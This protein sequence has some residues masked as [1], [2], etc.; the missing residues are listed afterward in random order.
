[1]I[2]SC[3]FLCLLHSAFSQI[4][5]VANGNN[6]ADGFNNSKCS[7]SSTPTSI[8]LFPYD[9]KFEQQL[10]FYIINVANTL[11]FSSSG[12]FKMV[13]RYF[14][15]S[16]NCILTT[17]NTFLTQIAL[18]ISNNARL[19]I[20]ANFYFANDINIEN[21]QL[22]LPRIVVWNS[23][24]IQLFKTVTS[25]FPINIVNPTTNN[26]C[27]DVFSIRNSEVLNSGEYKFGSYNSTDFPLTLNS[28]SL[29]LLSNKKL[30][31]FCPKYV[32]LDKNVV[33]KL[34]SSSYKTEY[35]V[36][37]TEKYP[38]EYPHCPCESNDGTICTLKLISTLSKFDF[39]KSMMMNTSV[40]VEHNTDI[41]NV[42]SVKEFVISDNVKSTITG[43]LTF[44]RYSFS[45]GTAR[46]TALTAFIDTID[47]FTNS[48]S[49]LFLCKHN[50]SYILSFNNSVKQLKV[51]FN[52]TISNFTFS[53]NSFFEIGKNVEQ[54]NTISVI[55]SYTE[56]FF[57]VTNTKILYSDMANC[58][59]FS[60]NK[61]R[62][63][64]IECDSNYYLI[65]N[66]CQ[67]ITPDCDIFNLKNKCVLCKSG[68][69]LSENGECLTSTTSCIVGSYNNCI[70]CK[71]GYINQ[72][73]TCIKNDNCSISDGNLCLKC[74]NG[75]IRGSCDVKCGNENCELCDTLTEQDQNS[76][77]FFNNEKCV[78]CEY[79]H[80]FNKTTFSCETVE[81]NIQIG[82]SYVIQNSII[83]CDDSY[84]LEAQNCINCSLKYSNSKVCNKNYILE[85]RDNYYIEENDLCVST[86]CINNNQVIDLNGKCVTKIDNCL[87]HLNG[88]CVECDNGYYIVTYF[89]DINKTLIT[90]CSL[91]NMTNTV[92]QNCL[93]NNPFGCI[94]CKDTYYLSNG[95]CHKCGEECDNC[96][97]TNSTCITCK[98]D[99]Y[100]SKNHKCI[101]NK[102]LM[103]KCVKFLEASSGCSQCKDGYYRIGL[104]CEL[105][106]LKCD[107]C[108][109]ET[110][111]VTC[112][113]SYYKTSTGDCMSKSNID[114]C[115]V[116]ITQKGCS[117]CEDGYY[118]INTNECA[119]CSSNCSKC[120]SYNI[121]I[122]CDSDKIL[123]N[124]KCLQ[125]SLIS[126]CL[127]IDNSKCEKCEFWH[128]PSAT[129]M[130]C[131]SKAAWWVI[132]II[133]V[134]IIIFI[135][136]IFIV[137]VFII[138]CVIF[139]LKENEINAETC[140]FE[141]KRSN[142]QFV[143]LGNDTVVNK[144]EIIFNEGE[145]VDV[146]K[147]TRELFCV[148]NT[149]KHNMKVQLTTKSENE[150]ITIDIEP[151]FIILKSQFACEFEIFVTL[152]CTTKISENLVVVANSFIGD[153]QI[154][155]EIKYY[156]SSKLSSKLD[157]DE[158]IEE[159]KLGEGS[160][161][162]VY[163]GTFRGNTVAIKK[164]KEVSLNLRSR[165]VEFEKEVNMLDKFRSEYIVHFYGAVFIPNH[166]CMVTEFAEYGS[167][168]DLIKHKKS[169]EI[170]N[171]IRV[172][173]LLDAG[174]GILYLH[175]NGILH[176]DIKPDNILVFSLEL[177]QQ[178]NAKLTDFGSSRNINMMMTNMTFT[179]GIGTPVY[180]A[181]EVLK[182]EHYK[183]PADVY[184]FA[185]TMY[186]TFI[187]GDAFPQNE[188]K[189]PWK[190]ADE[191]VSGNRPHYIC[192]VEQKY[193]NVIEK[194]WT[195]NSME[196]I[197][198]E[199]I[200]TLLK[201]LY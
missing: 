139:K 197:S 33:C 93:L 151:K 178:V 81:Y 164:M 113:T 111:C 107:T 49:N 9:F 142:I 59:L 127:K 34:I 80:F 3:L 171:K 147:K 83:S 36:N 97:I 74:S 27:F 38:F 13:V 173:M 69:L 17:E 125:L 157:Y 152:K 7:T 12:S 182:K 167:L 21:P 117:E 60:V 195:Q 140:M 4:T 115:N 136:A 14:E 122:S 134:I 6:W 57:H 5:C 75:V 96:A 84:Y 31:R 166:I 132:F 76:N 105:C 58:I 67:Y 146:D 52:G 11:T 22:N 28:G 18:N 154:V 64:C 170:S 201:E 150:K 119:Q 133:I 87:Y 25:F 131:E 23:S 35:I 191:I 47:F 165:M 184:S 48:S 24:S 109:S 143:T 55:N 51:D 100:L 181:P 192:T 189:Y 32:T 141:M 10:T 128:S 1:M 190:I 82:L 126:K 137:A 129:G 199:G 124:G 30:H 50:S 43:F 176:R 46:F 179:K 169:D 120:S 19:N 198:I 70:M 42:N 163:K 26:K 40:V 161:G 118:I 200:I 56:S 66:T 29:Y 158:L 78:L 98:K 37:Q 172:K 86:E 20:N 102:E 156:V 62:R 85:C 104:E 185:I 155:K 44:S 160:F 196:R 130:F 95:Q 61:T 77:N 90:Y 168:Q 121:C 108:I 159:K 41:I 175:E 54:I 186:E 138:K 63:V 8:Y 73:G 193:R 72:R 106:P 89:D 149:S 68:F 116:P 39:K 177:N 45:F 91:L 92:Y 53:G 101:S 79:N 144:K 188:Y 145:D 15:I 94:K 187:W 71:S 2:I 103:D 194:S 174:K 180:M 114:H 153:K 123:S 65:N 183:K 112:N 162:V 16:K 110:T 99:F 135:L 88:K 148:G